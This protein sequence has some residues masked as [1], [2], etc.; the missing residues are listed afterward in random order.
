MSFPPKYTPSDKWSAL[1]RGS[2]QR[3]SNPSIEAT[4]SRK[5]RKP[6]HPPINSL[7]KVGTLVMFT[8]PVGPPGANFG[9]WAETK[10]EAGTGPTS[11]SSGALL[12]GGTESPGAAARGSSPAAFCHWALRT[13]SDSPAR[14]SPVCSLHLAALGTVKTSS[15]SQEAPGWARSR[16]PAVLVAEPSN[17]QKN[18]PTG[19]CWPGNSPG[20][21]RPQDVVSRGRCLPRLAHE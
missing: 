21:L 8:V 13:P 15:S 19:T 16:L 11:R 4:T 5:L 10:P 18:L 6:Q 17:P 2:C 9:C 3:S 1:P 12:C 14:V 7:K 20:I